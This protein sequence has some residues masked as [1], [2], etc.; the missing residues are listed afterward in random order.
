L[1]ASAASAAA[2]H[3]PAHALGTIFLF[4]LLI[5]SGVA[6][7]VPAL[8]TAAGSGIAL[9]ALA[10][11]ALANVALAGAA[12][13]AGPRELPAEPAA[14]TVPN[15][16]FAATAAGVFLFVA[17][18]MMVWSYVGAE[19]LG[20]GL[21]DRTIGLGV[22]LGSLAG[23]AAAW[24]VAHRPAL[25]PATVAALAAAIAM[26]A[27]LLPIAGAGSFLAAMILFNLGATYAVPRFSALAIDRNGSATA[28][29]LIPAL[30]S[31]AMIVGPVAAAVA[32]QTRGFAALAMLASATLLAAVLALLGAAALERNGKPPARIAAAQQEF[33]Q[34]G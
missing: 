33:S 19:A 16:A 13:D 9:A 23:V 5:A 10:V 17:A 32:V 7:V 6:L 25:L 22:A 8:G 30:H 31:I 26:A 20:A 21:G 1:Y 24:L 3:D 14:T 27:P 12:A 2:R 11:A 28:R 34:G 4:Q 29:R 18:S 15:A